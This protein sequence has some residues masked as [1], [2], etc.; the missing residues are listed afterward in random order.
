MDLQSY[1]TYLITFVNNILI[2]FILGIAFLF[3]VV[4][5]FRFFILG[6]SNPESQD[7]AKSL[8]IYGVGAFVFII[9]FWGIVNILSSSLGLDFVPS[10]QLCPDYNP[11]CALPSDCS[12]GGPC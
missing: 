9:I 5:V 12:G 6:G 10:N 11:N 1:V 3:F 7:K 2:P 4:N 8:A